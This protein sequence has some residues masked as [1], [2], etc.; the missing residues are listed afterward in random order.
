M[1]QPKNKCTLN[2][3]PLYQ[4]MVLWTI[5]GIFWYL[6]FSFFIT[7]AAVSSTP[8]LDTYKQPI[9]TINEELQMEKEQRQVLDYL[10]SKYSKLYD[11]CRFR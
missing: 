10:V 11:S 2:D 7:D 6:F 3:I 9:Y 8:P 5:S 4:Y 1:T